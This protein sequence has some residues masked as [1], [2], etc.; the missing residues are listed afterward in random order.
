MLIS[1]TSGNPKPMSEGLAT[2]SQCLPPVMS[3]TFIESLI[4]AVE[5]IQPERTGAD[6]LFRAWQYLRKFPLAEANKDACSM[7]RDRWLGIEFPV[8]GSVL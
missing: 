6:L 5:T 3:G 1:S 8:Y 2:S 4:N 7:L